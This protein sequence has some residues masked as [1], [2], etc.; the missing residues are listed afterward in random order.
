LQIHKGWEDYGEYKW[1]FTACDGPATQQFYRY[2]GRMIDRFDASTLAPPAVAGSLSFAAEIGS[3]GVWSKLR[4]SSWVRK[5]CKQ[6]VLRR[7][8]RYLTVILGTF[9]GADCAIPTALLKS[10]LETQT[11]SAPHA[12]ID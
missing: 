2:T 8:D 1:G 6:R 11:S 4:Q 12:L 5:G 9:F 10:V 7:L 3:G